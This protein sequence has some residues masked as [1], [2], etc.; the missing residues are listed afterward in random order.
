M[1]VSGRLKWP[2][3]MTLTQNNC[4]VYDQLHVGS[5]EKTCEINGSEERNGLN[6]IDRRPFNIQRDD[7]THHAHN[8]K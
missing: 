7:K 3:S 6:Y 4:N 8:E 1:H 5:A 2:L